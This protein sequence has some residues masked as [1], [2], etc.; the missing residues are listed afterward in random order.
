MDHLKA[1]Y[2]R[3]LSEARI[4]IVDDEPINCEIMSHVLGD[5]YKVSSVNSGE[6]AIEA[7]FTLSPDLILMD[8]MMGGMSGIQTCRLIKDTEAISHIPVIFI[9][10]VQHE[11]EQSEC[12]DA[13]GVDFVAKPVNGIELCNRVR[14]HLTHKFQT[15]LLLK[16]T[17]VDKLTGVYNRHFLDDIIPKLEKQALRSHTPVSILMVDIDWFKLYN[18]HFGHVQGDVCLREVA[19]AISQALHRSTDQ[20]ARFGGEE[21]I[22]LLADTDLKG[23]MHVAKAI[24][25]KIGDCKI[26]HPKSSFGRVT[27]SI[28]VAT[29]T[30][31]DSMTLDDTIKLADKQLYLAK[32][33]GRNQVCGVS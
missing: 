31:S 9:T 29:Y 20:L 1:K 10:A 30:T 6:A 28:G 23:A 7:C 13:G 15:D 5:L 4:L 26:I 27:V 21:F 16:L 33:Q 14:A 22:A 11:H 3:S 19:N 24:I 8:V 2:A 18:D 17:Y 12:W 25:A 32:T